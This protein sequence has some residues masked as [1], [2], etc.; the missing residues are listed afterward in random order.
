M[1]TKP[2]DGRR[3]QRKVARLEAERREARNKRLRT[4][5]LV[6]IPTLV[7]L[8]VLA[9]ALSGRKAAPT[10]P[11]VGVHQNDPTTAAGKLYSHVADGTAINY[12]HYP[13]SFGPHY[14]DP[15]NWGA[16]DSAVP[17]GNFVHDLE[18]GGVVLLYRCPSGCPAT[19]E[20]LKGLLTSLP[21][22]SF[23]EVK[24]VISPYQRS[25]HLITALAWDYELDL[26]SFDA[27][28]IEA[29]YQA[30]VDH[31]PERVA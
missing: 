30:H 7:V 15:R 1:A 22:D 23:G 3:D 19:V 4:Y 24:V 31:S 27:N 11:N 17:E 28:A 8:A 18:H 14:P 5:G 20:K 29:F 26:N 6:A 2:R 12:S 16:Y 9:V 21:K 13:P 25:T 10:G